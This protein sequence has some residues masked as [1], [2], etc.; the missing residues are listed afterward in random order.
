MFARQRRHWARLILGFAAA[1]SGAAVSAETPPTTRKLPPAVTITETGPTTLQWEA[2][3]PPVKELPESAKSETPSSQPIESPSPECCGFDWSKVPPARPT[4][5]L[6]NFPILPKGSGYY[7]LVDQ[8]HHR[9]REGPPKYGYPPYALMPTP[10]FDADFR[11][12]DEA[13]DADWSERLKRI[14]LGDSWLF[15]TGGQA[16]G[17]YMHENGSRLTLTDN[18]YGLGRVRTFG[19]LWYKDQFRAYVEFISAQT[20]GQSLPPLAI[21]RNYADFQ[22]LFIEA[23]LF[24]IDGRGAYLRVGRQEL[25]FGSQRLIST[26]DWANT[27]RTFQ[28]A[29]AYRQG[30]K[31]DV[32]LFWVQPVVPNPTQLDSVDNNQ[33][34][35]GIWTTYRPEPGHAIDAYYLFLDN[36]NPVTQL[37]IVR[38]P[39]NVHTLGAR[40]SGDRNGFLWDVEAAVQMGRR[41]SSDIIAGMATVGAGYNFCDVPMNP[42]F[43]VY[44]DY[45]SGDHTPNSGNFSTFNQLSPFGHYYLGWAD[46]IGRQNIHDFN[47]HLYLYPTKWITFWTQYH[48]FWLDQRRDALYNIAGN[49]SRRSAN[50]SAGNDV[51]HEIDFVLNFH[52]AKRHDIMTGYSRLFGGDFLNLT[53]GTTGAT[54]SDIFYLMYNYRW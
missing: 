19:D 8:I 13:A 43:W 49:A 30:E 41:G 52:L 39:F 23:K 6:G 54:N 14:H 50:G 28:G 48:R 25:L 44:Y 18:D 15:A 42:T 31:F 17:R 36:T 9:Y 29:R 11:Y 38:A 21:D 12:V 2:S 45:A 16:W 27:R 20:E 22:N 32:D 5:R 10:L 4:Q 35:A 3:Q 40:Y 1:L 46:L 53:R 47:L 26:L 33:N 24:E 34:F 7:S 51:G 37:G